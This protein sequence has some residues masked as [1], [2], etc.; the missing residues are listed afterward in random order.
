L[1][2]LTVGWRLAEG[3][4]GQGHGSSSVLRVGGGRVWPAL[5]VRRR[6]A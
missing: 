1:L 2:F 6:L 4:R 5:K 3:R